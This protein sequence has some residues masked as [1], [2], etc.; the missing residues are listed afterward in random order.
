MPPVLIVGAGALGSFLA[1]RLTLAGYETTVLARGERR[2]QLRD[3]GIRLLSGQAQSVV[4][5]AVPDI[6]APLPPARVVLLC[7]KAA[8]LPASLEQAAAVVGPD[9]V[10][11]TVQNGVDAP[12]LV[13]SR[14]PQATVLAARVHGFFEMEQGLVRHVGVEPSLVFGPTGQDGAADAECFRNMLAR[15]A[16]TGR[17]SDNIAADLW[18]KLVLTSAFGGLGAATG[19]AAGGLRDSPDYWR[20]LEA[21][22]A[23][24]ADLARLRGIVLDP[25]CTARTLAFVR[26]F[27]ADATTSMQRDFEAGRLSEYASLGGAVRRMARESGLPVPAHDRIA[28]AIAARFPDAPDWLI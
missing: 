17:I 19:L 10:L 8:G 5:V 3:G 21:A 15:A 26:S 11:V 12:G 4:R 9:T 6:G 2:G 16:I 23:E 7:T 1:A 28:A 20:W 14:F 27:P 13:A 18:E 24:V 25:G 22:M